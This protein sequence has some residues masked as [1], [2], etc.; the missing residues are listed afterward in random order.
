MSYNDDTIK[1][2][3]IDDPCFSINKNANP[4]YYGYEKYWGCWVT[5]KATRTPDKFATYYR[6]DGSVGHTFGE[7]DFKRMCRLMRKNAQEHIYPMSEDTFFNIVKHLKYASVD[8]LERFRD[9]ISRIF[10]VQP[11]EQDIDILE[12]CICDL[13][14]HDFE[15]VLQRLLMHGAGRPDLCRL[16]IDSRADHVFIVTPRV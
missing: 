6:E 3:H 12:E 1:V 8:Q 14:N 5:N 15:N 13:P 16:Q 11:R 9:E 10:G 4:L 2:Y 7:Q